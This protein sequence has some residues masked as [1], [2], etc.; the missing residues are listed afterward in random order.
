MRRLPPLKVAIV[1]HFGD[2]RRERPKI[3]LTIVVQS[4]AVAR[5]FYKTFV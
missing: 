3:A 1:E 2:T 5:H 4:Y